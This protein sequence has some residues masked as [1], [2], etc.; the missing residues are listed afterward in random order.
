MLISSHSPLLETCF[1]LPIKPGRLGQAPGPFHHLAP[2]YLASQQAQ[3]NTLIPTSRLPLA[4]FV[5]PEITST[6]SA[7]TSA[8]IQVPTPPEA[9]PDHANPWG[10]SPLTLNIPFV[11]F[12]FRVCLFP[13]LELD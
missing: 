13:T 10:S 11:S 5:Y 7:P 1:P 8:E 4:L 9:F 6:S 2:C 3:P 12:S